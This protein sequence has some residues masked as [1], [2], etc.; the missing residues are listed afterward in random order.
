MR[1]QSGS[2]IRKFYYS[3]PHL[4]SFKHE[5]EEVDIHKFSLIKFETFWLLINMIFKVTKFITISLTH[6]HHGVNTQTLSLFL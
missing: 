3:W 4:K 2:E 6:E 5:K 1:K